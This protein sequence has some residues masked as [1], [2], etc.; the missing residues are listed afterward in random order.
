MPLINYIRLVALLRGEPHLTAYVHFN[1]KEA[2]VY[3][4]ARDAVAGLFVSVNGDPVAVTSTAPVTMRVTILEDTPGG[5]VISLVGADYP[6]GTLR[7]AGT[8]ILA[9]WSI[10]WSIGAFIGAL[11][12]PLVHSVVH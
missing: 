10:R 11:T 6:S 7:Q 8:S 2:L 5:A 9:H 3:N 4:R 12:G 1:Y